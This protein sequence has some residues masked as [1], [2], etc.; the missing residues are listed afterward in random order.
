MRLYNNTFHFLGT[1]VRELRRDALVPRTLAD[2]FLYLAVP[3]EAVVGPAVLFRGS[4][5]PDAALAPSFALAAF[6]YGLLFALLFLVGLRRRR[7]LVAAHSF[8]LSSDARSDAGMQSA[9]VIDA[10]CR[11]ML[12]V[13]R[14]A[15]HSDEIDAVMLAV[16]AVPEMQCGRSN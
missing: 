7:G 3:P 10:S 14:T 16:P 9:A 4:F 15:R 5:R 1:L 8:L 11:L 12:A 2:P 13:P 6:L